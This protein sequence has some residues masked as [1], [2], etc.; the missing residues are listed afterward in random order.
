M[1]SR[2]NKPRIPAP[3]IAA[4]IALLAWFGVLGLA[5]VNK[6]H[7]EDWWRL[8]SYDPP[9]AVVQIASQDT[10]TDYGRKIF[11]AN[12]PE[13]ISKSEFAAKCPAHAEE[14]IVLGC[15]HSGQGGVYL[16]D[17]SDP[18]LEGVEQVTAAHE[19]L[20]AAYERLSSKEKNQVNAWLEQYYKE[21]L[22]D[23]RIKDTLEAY[24][25]SKRADL[26]NEMHSIFPTELPSL[27]QHLETYYRKYFTDRAQ[28]ANFAAQYQAEF[29]S[30]QAQIDQAD[31]QLA[32]LKS[33][34]DSLEADISRQQGDI[35]RREQALQ[36]LRD[37][38]RIA[39]YN[40]GVAPYNQLI[41]G[42]NGQIAR[43]QALIKQH[44][45]LVAYRNAIALEE[46]Q[47]AEQLR[48]PKAQPINN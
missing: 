6:Q 38:G 24:K 27:P 19:M 40:A 44:N 43:V 5:A 34:I 42:Y 20:H 1:L 47:L 45:D 41:D 12:Q 3:K 22:E 46:S 36:N 32:E 18:R 26:I 16:L 29:T 37:S 30:R 2:P 35:Q 13:L 31:N 4:V 8:R 7:I 17:V 39:E 23:P 21:N 10:M 15:Y 33:Q 9:Q 28:V 48:P 11:Y 25:G 14:T